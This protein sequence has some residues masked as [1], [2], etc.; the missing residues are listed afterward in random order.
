MK[1]NALKK[2]WHEI[3]DRP[4]EGCV[5]EIRH[6]YKKIIIMRLL[7]IA[8]ILMTRKKTLMRKPTHLCLANSTWISTKEKTCCETSSEK[9]SC[10]LSNSGHVTS[11]RQFKPACWITRK[12]TQRAN[13]LCE[14]D[15]Q[16]VF[17]TS[18]TRGR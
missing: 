12:K 3:K 5:Q 9:E 15:E 14:K 2:K 6:M 8:T 10:T 17:R 16:S 18:K 13:E 11:C 1:Y 7:V 4:K